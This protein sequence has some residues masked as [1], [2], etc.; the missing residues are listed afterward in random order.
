MAESI[1]ENEM[2]KKMANEIER[3]FRDGLHR[4][5]ADK[6]KPAPPLKV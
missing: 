5:T 3:V 6:G 2:D 1:M 4:D